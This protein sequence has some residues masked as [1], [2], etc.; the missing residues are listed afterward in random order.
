MVRQRPEP[1]RP[2]ALAGEQARETGRGKLFLRLFLQNERREALAGCI[3][4]LTPQDR[5]LL[6][7]RFTQGAS[8][9]AIAA[10][11][12][13]S[14]DTVYKSLARI[15]RALFECVTRRL[16]TEEQP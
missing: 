15:R 1:A 6:T 2:D 16:A 7:R 4:K 8:V 3:E 9:Q 13:R 12:G 11:F 10:Q 5:D 14:A